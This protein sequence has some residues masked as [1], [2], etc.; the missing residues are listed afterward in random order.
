LSGPLF[1][2][3]ICD[4]DVLRFAPSLFSG[5]PQ[6]HSSRYVERFLVSSY[7]LLYKVSGSAEGK[8]PYLLTAHMDVVPAE[9][10][11]WDHPPFSGAIVDGFI[12]G[13]GAIDDKGSVMVR[14]FDY[15]C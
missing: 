9:P 1:K 12:Y 13:R 5:F 7:S 14:T 8:L 3:S 11:N 4:D 6:I 2:Q 10:D 15:L